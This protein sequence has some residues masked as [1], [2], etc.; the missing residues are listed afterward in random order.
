[1]GKTEYFTDPAA[2][3]QLMTSG[4]AVVKNVTLIGEDMVM[5]RHV[6]EDLF[7]ESLPNVNVCVAAFTTSY[8]RLELYK[9][10]EMLPTRLLYTDT[11]S[12]IFVGLKN[13]A[14]NP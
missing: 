14:K 6:K 5:V 4:E 7:V 2:Y 11:D 12:V 10:M 1:M 8:A 13:L 9:Y 3:L